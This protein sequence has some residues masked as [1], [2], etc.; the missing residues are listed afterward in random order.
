MNLV[1]RLVAGTAAMFLIAAA[2]ALAASGV[3]STV[4]GTGFAGFAGDGGSAFSARIDLPRA[5]SPLPDGGFLIADRENDRVRRVW[6]NLAITTVAGSGPTGASNG[7]FAGDG[8]PATSARL[9]FLHDAEPTPDGGFLISDTRNERI[10]DVS[11]GGTIETVA[12]SGPFGSFADGAFSGDGGPAGAARLDNPHGLAVNPDGSYLIAD[13]DNN[14]VREVATDG[15]ISTVAGSG[16][17][18]N[19]NGGF[20][21]DGGPATSARLNRPFDVDPTADGGFLIADTGNKVIR[22]VAPD[23][24]I[25]TVAGIP[26]A[27]GFS[28]DGGPA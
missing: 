11:P 4:A 21:G 17:A 1:A 22:R 6:P 10:R 15:T 14:R 12:G 3:I 23:G 18:G 8:G 5:V 13:T 2:P 16:P 20:S 28:G 19:G 25:T 26:G 9:D 24:T 27:Q 7:A